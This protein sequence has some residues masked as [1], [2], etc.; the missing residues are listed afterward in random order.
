MA[1]VF[2]SVVRGIFGSEFEMTWVL[3]ECCMYITECSNGPRRVQEA[4]GMCFRGENLEMFIK[5][6]L[7]NA[8]DSNEGVWR[9][10]AWGES[11]GNRPNS[12][13]HCNRPSGRWQEGNLMW[14]REKGRVEEKAM[15]LGLGYKKRRFRKQM[16]LVWLGLAACLAKPSRCCSQRNASQER[17][18][19]KDGF[20]LGNAGRMFE[21]PI[22]WHLQR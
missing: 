1:G 3:R 22:A 18:K 2:R 12:K 21:Y 11:R 17:S 6:Y 15:C 5:H 8:S 4:I 13:S 20:T 10:E 19:P 7:S 14:Q 16:S 9:A